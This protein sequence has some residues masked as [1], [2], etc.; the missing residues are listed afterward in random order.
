MSINHKKLCLK[1]ACHTLAGLLLFI[2][3]VPAVRA[4]DEVNISGVVR[5]SSGAVLVD[6]NISL[7]N[8]QSAIISTTKT[9]AQGR[10]TISNVPEGSYVLVINSQGF[11]ENRTV[12]NARAAGI[13]EISVTLEPR[14]ASEEVTVTALTGHVECHP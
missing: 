6:A 4:G 8:A 12:V 14:A 2:S 9:D 11:T 3:L 10:F 1:L 5:D 7:L 13:P